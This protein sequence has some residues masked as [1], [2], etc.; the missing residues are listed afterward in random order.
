MPE[1]A[2]RRP[3][4]PGWAVNGIV[5]Y[6]LALQD[7][8]NGLEITFDLDNA[9]TTTITV[10]VRILTNALSGVFQKRLTG[11][12][13]H[14]LFI[15]FITYFLLSIASLGLIIGESL[16]N[17]G[18]E[19]LF[20]SILTGVTGALGNGCI[21]KA[22]Q[23]GELSVLGPVNAWKSVV[24][25]VTAFVLIGE[26]PNWLGVG[27]IGLIIVGS[28]VVLG[29]G[30]ERL[31][32]T[33]FRQPAIR[34]RLLA[35]VLTGIQAVF[36]KQVIRYS[37]LRLAFASWAVAGALFALLILLV[38]RIDLRVELLKIDRGVIGRGVIGNYLLLT[39]LIGL[40]VGSTN[41][42]FSLMPVAAALSLFQLSLLLS[43][44]FGVK[45]F[46]ETG[47]WRKLAGASIMIAGSL[48]ILLE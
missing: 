39:I 34:Y 5:C 26:R 11:Q 48:L 7:L 20:Y 10:A 27:G 21:V 35:L 25:L 32:W 45:L 16:P 41:L 3:A 30:Q 4:H 31:S 19:F 9:I 40:M 6:C 46:N 13:Q 28:Y 14:P 47:L 18:R 29:G 42:A 15:N 2:G 37:N 23:T 44:I 17:P 43:V 24:G 22:L 38:R 12:S 33:I 8:G 1:H 36:D